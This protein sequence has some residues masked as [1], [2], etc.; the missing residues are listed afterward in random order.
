MAR[1]KTSQFGA[2]D[3]LFSVSSINN[4]DFSYDTQDVYATHDTYEVH[5]EPGM[6]EEQEVHEV[7]EVEKAQETPVVH[8][9]RIDTK[10]TLGSTQGRKGEKLKRI[11]LAFDDENYEYVRLESRRRGKSITQFVNEIIEEYRQSAKGR[12]CDA[13]IR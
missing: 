1:N 11:N 12:I 13:E 6:Q 2:A 5:E 10:K 8:D 4:S 3:G 9:A 7:H